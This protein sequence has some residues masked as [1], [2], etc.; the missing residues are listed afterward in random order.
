MNL[1]VTTRYLKCTSKRCFQSKKDKE[2]FQENCY[3][4]NQQNHIAKNCQKLKKQVIAVIK[5]LKG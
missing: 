4:C 5:T 2:K 1:N 3:N